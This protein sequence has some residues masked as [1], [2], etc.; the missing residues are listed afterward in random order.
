MNLKAL[1][2]L[3]VQL[4][5]DEGLRLHMYLDTAGKPTIGYGRN[6]I[7]RGI[8]EDE[9]VYLLAN[10]ITSVVFNLD[11]DLSWWSG[12]DEVRQRVLASMCFNLGIRGLLN[13]RRTLHC[14]RLSD[15]VGAAAGMRASLWASQV[16][17]RAEKLARMMETGEDA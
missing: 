10:D 11:R 1:E 7:D 17:A 2:A 15:W 12:L 5:A 8:T 16:G 14:M 6:L 4:M 9:A 3:S 13:F